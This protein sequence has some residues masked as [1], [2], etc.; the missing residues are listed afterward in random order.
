MRR[1]R[2]QAGEVA[3]YPISRRHAMRRVAEQLL[4]GLDSSGAPLPVQVVSDAQHGH[5]IRVQLGAAQGAERERLTRAVHERLDPL[6]VR[7][8]VA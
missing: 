5:V 2:G 6:T 1:G 4:E 8:E 3:D 7:H